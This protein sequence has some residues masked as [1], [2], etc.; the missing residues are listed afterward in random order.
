MK[1]PPVDKSVCLC[2]GLGLEKNR[3]YV[4][5]EDV[6][7]AK[8][9]GITLRAPHSGVAHPRCSFDLGRVLAIHLQNKRGVKP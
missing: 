4:R 5:M 7:L 3:D 2:C 9:L 1:S 8:S 6:K